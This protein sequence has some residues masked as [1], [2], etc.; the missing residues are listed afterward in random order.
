MVL[1][2]ENFSV[3]P[4]DIDSKF[5]PSFQVY[6]RFTEVLI[7]S[8]RVEKKVILNEKKLDLKKCYGARVYQEEQSI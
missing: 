7:K 3:F 4:Q 1:I 6:S 8:Y 2:Q 5:W